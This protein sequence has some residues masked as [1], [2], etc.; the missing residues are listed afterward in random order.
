MLGRTI[1]QNLLI[2]GTILTNCKDYLIILFQNEVG[3]TRAIQCDWATGPL[4][5]WL[6]VF[7]HFPCAL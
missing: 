2:Y 6:P 5:A 7:S 4:E 3:S 1:L